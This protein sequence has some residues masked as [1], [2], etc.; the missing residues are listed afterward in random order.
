MRLSSIKAQLS[1]AGAG[2]WLSLAKCTGQ[3]NHKHMK[4]AAKS[5]FLYRVSHKSQWYSF[6]DN[7]S[8]NYVSISVFLKPCFLFIFSIGRSTV[9]QS[10]S[11][12]WQVSFCH[13]QAFEIFVTIK[14]RIT[15]N[16]LTRMKDDNLGTAVFSHDIFSDSNISLPPL[17]PWLLWRCI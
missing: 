15:R 2:V 6:I 1:P 17:Y 12:P 11:S 4:K 7:C 14:T 16:I 3:R 5:L 10:V 13:D 9:W 8:C